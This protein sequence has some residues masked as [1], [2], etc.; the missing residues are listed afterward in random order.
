MAIMKIIL[1]IIVLIFR[2]LIV[3][4]HDEEKVNGESNT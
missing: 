3:M 1:R 4:T 2:L